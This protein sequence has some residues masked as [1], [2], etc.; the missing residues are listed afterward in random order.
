MVPRGL[1]NNQ[2]G[3]NQAMSK[4]VLQGTACEYITSCVYIFI[5]V[6]CL[7]NYQ[8]DDVHLLPVWDKKDR[9]PTVKASPSCRFQIFSVIAK[10]SYSRSFAKHFSRKWHMK[11]M[12]NW[13][14]WLIR[15]IYIYVVID[16]VMFIQNCHNHF[17][18]CDCCDLPVN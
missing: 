4:R 1:E 12:F 16:S 18:C 14:E 11:I 15:E 13:G 5:G 8:L 9:L 6:I 10:C 7:F 17:K 3:W 2:K